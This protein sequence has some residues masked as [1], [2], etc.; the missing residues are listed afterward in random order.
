MTWALSRRQGT[1]AIV[2][3]LTGAVLVHVCLINVGPRLSPDLALQAQGLYAFIAAALIGKAAAFG[4]PAFVWLG[5]GLHVIVSLGWAFGY[6]Y[7]SRKLPQLIRRPVISGLGFGLVVYFVM[8][9]VLVA[10][11]LYT[12]PTPGSVGIGLLADCVFF[13][14]PVA[15]IVAGLTRGT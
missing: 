2:A 14:V 3:G 5:V 7:A 9:L 6:A 12:K 4:N 13:G 1:A 15:L 11:N 8:E 10:A